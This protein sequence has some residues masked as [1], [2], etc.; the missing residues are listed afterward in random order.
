MLKLRFD[1]Y[2]TKSHNAIR[3]SLPFYFLNSADPTIS[4]PGTGYT[5]SWGGAL[6][7]DT[8][9]G[10]VAE[11]ELRQDIW[12]LVEIVLDIFSGISLPAEASFPCY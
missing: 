11:T 9:N 6:C 3:L 10:C 12:F 2:I 4:E 1:R 5:A 8:K 7:D